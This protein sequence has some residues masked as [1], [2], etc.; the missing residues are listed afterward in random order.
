VLGLIRDTKLVILK[1]YSL[2]S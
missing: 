1:V 2:Q